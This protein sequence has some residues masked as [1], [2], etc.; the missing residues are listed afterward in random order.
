MISRDGTRVRTW[1]NGASGVPLVISN[2]FGAP[3]SAWPRLAEPDCGF[4]AVSWWHRGLGGSERPE[5]RTRIRV[6]D[7]A[8]DLEATMDAVGHERAVVLGWSLG[9]NVAFEFAR[10]RPDRVAGIL[11]VGGVPGRSVHAFGPPGLPGALRAGAGRAAAWSLRLLGPPAAALAWPAVES[12]RALGA[13]H[14]PPFPDPVPS[15]AVARQ[16]AAHPWSWYS[17]LLLAAGDQPAAGTGSVSFPVTLVSG[18]Y[19]VGAAAPDVRAAAA[20]IPHA[21]FVPLVGSHFLP[22][23]QPDGVHEELVSLAARCSFARTPRG[24]PGQERGRAPVGSATARSARARAA[25]GRR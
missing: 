3:P 18:T 25:R 24:L 2:G 12:A 23:E 10:T 14:L 17:E 19:D 6:E 20:A 11:G 8:A 7:H 13:R 16:F 15:A 4:A 5:D 21:R 9:V 1:A 22:L